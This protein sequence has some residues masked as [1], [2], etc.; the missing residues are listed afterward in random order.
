[1]VKLRVL[2]AGGGTGGHI[3]P[4]LAVARELVARHA[5]DVPFA[6]ACVYT[7]LPSP[8]A[9]SLQKRMGSDDKQKPSAERGRAGERKLR[10]RACSVPL[11]APPLPLYPHGV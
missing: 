8:G 5:A 2:I 11:S 1:M 9:Q 7:Q 6:G 4:A 3:L 10:L